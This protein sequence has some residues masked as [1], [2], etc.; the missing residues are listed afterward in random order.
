MSE[1]DE[2]DEKPDLALVRDGGNTEPEPQ[3]EITRT[4]VEEG[5]VNF[6][7]LWPFKHGGATGPTPWG[8]TGIG[9]TTGTWTWPNGPTGPTGAIGVKGPIGPVGMPGPP[10]RLNV[11]VDPDI[12][13]F[14]DDDNM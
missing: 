6:P 11:D 1:Q 14:N 7:P 9:P 4:Y 8:V 3:T 5:N 12:E 13:E 10:G 2:Q